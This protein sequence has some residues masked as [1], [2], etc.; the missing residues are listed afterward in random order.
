M[1]DDIINQSPPRMQTSSPPRRVQRVR[2]EIRRRDLTVARIVPVGANTVAITFAGESLEDFRSDSFDDHVKFMLDADS[3]EPVRRDYTPRRFDRAARELTIE[4]VLHGH[5]A[6]SDWARSA[7]PG[8]R[9]TVAGPR[10]SM[11]IPTDYDWHLLAGDT[12][13]LPAIQRRLEELP[14]GT[15]AVVVAQAAD[16]GDR[17]EFT[18]AARLDVHWVA[19]SD[20]LHAAI[21][22]LTF[23]SGEGFVWCAGEAGAMARLRKLLIEQKHHPREAMRVAA[24]WKHGASAFHENLES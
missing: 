13:A 21:A 6:A 11:I 14:A 8:Q 10:G 1:I 15:R 16:A 9:A 3:A 7:A 22:A 19:D 2:H 24:Y 20:A 18:S 23:P 4:F 12:T 17:R 5:G